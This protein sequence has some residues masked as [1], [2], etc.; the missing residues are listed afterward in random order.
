[1]TFRRRTLVLFILA[2]AGLGA[3]W[4]LH[5]PAPV[6]VKVLAVA[7]G[8][9]EEIVANTRAGT[10]KP[11]RRAKLA[12]SLGGQIATLAVREG[13]RVKTGDLLLE[14]W[15]QDLTAQVTLA[16]R[17]AEAAEARARSACLNAENAEREAA[18]QVKLDARR[19]TSQETLD[20]AI[21]AAQAGRADCEAAQATARVS[22]AKVGVAQANLAK[23][24]L[25]APFAGIVAEVSGELSEYVTPSPPG[26]PTPPAVDLIDDAC[27]YISAPIDEVD[28]AKVRL[29]AEVRVTLD[30]FGDRVFPG[31][32][33]RLA[34]YVL[35]LEKQARTLEVEVEL[36]DPAPELAWLAGYSADVEIVIERREA[37][38]RVPTAALKPDGTLL[39]LDPATGRL[40]ARKV[41]TGL[42]NWEQT[43]ITGG[44]E[45][46]ELVVLS[47]DQEGVEDGAL[48]VREDAKQAESRP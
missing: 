48:A 28:A 40:Q 11:C 31:R 17:E 4:Y 16:E 32:V 43:Q 46:G 39:V 8:T 35:D 26:I 42:A 21:T 44:L 41:Q 29:G 34:P 30:A 5:E 38:P 13:D 12:P 9:V 1:M 36:T 14:L 15:N 7:P 27:H 3:W 18:R 19:L 23:T 24:R 6:R 22:A 37:V 33:R 45:T 25:T 2:A 20:R 10:L 47:L